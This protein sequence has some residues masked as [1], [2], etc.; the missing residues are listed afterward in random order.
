MKR[1]KFNACMLILPVAAMAFLSSCG[2]DEDDAPKPTVTLSITGEKIT[3]NE[4]EVG[5][6]ISISASAT[7]GSENL[8]SVLFTVKINGGAAIT[9]F[10]SAVTG[11]S[12]TAMVPTKAVGSTGDDV[13]YILTVND[14]NGSS[15]Q[16]TVNLAIIPKLNSLDGA[17]NQIIYNF[18]SQG[19][20]VA[21]DLVAGF[22]LQRASAPIDQDLKD[23]TA[24]GAA[25]WSKTWTSGN[26]TKFIKVTANDWNNAS[27]TTY[28][29]NLYKAN[30][31]KMTAQYT[32]AE[33]DV[34]LIKSTQ[35][36]DFNIYLVKIGKL[37]D[38]PQIGN[39][40]DFV[41]FDYRGINY[42]K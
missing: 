40:N 31:D 19:Q 28:L 17:A 32:F 23:A 21:Y 14:A 30:K 26:G 12:F 25:Q 22:A 3:G 15:A 13:Q 7:A 27:S 8:K 20:N 5:S 11:K 33:G 42:P 29:F 38:L 37:T 18:N 1:M 35:A 2:G 39:N 16:A 6:D 36:V 41:Q 4:A 10:D 34:V 9:V 24:T